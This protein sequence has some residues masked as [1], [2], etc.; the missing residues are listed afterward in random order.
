MHFFLSYSSFKLKH[1]RYPLKVTC[2]KAVNNSF[3]FIKTSRANSTF[4]FSICSSLCPLFLLPSSQWLSLILCPF[5]LVSVFLPLSSLLLFLLLLVLPSLFIYFFHLVILY[6]AWFLKDDWKGGHVLC[7]WICLLLLR[8]QWIPSET[9]QMNIFIFVVNMPPHIHTF[10][11][12]IVC[13]TFL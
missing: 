8:S 2:F 4:P 5:L 10:I 12:S 6:V 7:T 3:F 9:L 1:F 13:V 11:L